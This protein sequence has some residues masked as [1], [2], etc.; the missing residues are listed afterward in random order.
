MIRK[1]QREL[2]P[3]Q[4]AEIGAR[5]AALDVEIR[6]ILS[7]LHGSKKATDLAVKVSFWVSRLR[8]TLDNLLLRDHPAQYSA[9]IYF[10][11]SAEGQPKAEAAKGAAR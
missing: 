3:H 9:E 4:H 7:K 8:G 2:T 6:S 11:R 5:L 10:P 1:S